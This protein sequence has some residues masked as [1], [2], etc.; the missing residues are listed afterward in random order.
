MMMSMEEVMVADVA[1]DTEEVEE[2]AV[3]I[4]EEDVVR[5]L[6]LWPVHMVQM[7]ISQLKQGSMKDLNIKP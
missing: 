1:V 5:T 2:D 6:T 3:E 7:Q 4:K